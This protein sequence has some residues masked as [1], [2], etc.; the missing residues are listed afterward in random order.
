MTTTNTELVKPSLPKRVPE[1]TLHPFCEIIP[2][3]TAKEFAELKEDIKK[4]GLQVPVKLLTDQI[5]DGRSRYNACI[6]LEKEGV[7]ID[8]K[9][10]A[11]SGTQKDALA[12]VISMNVKRRQLT[13]SQRAIIAAKLVNSSVGGDR[14]S[15]KLPN[16]VT[17]EDVARLSGVAKKMVTDAA[18][19][20]KAKRPDLADKVLKGELA[21][22]KAAKT[23]RQEEKAKKGNP[24]SEDD[25]KADKA[26]KAYHAL[27]EKLIDALSDLGK[28]SSLT[29]ARECAKSTKTR[30]DETIETLRKEEKEAA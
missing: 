7:R 8:F 5:L 17:Q 22:N 21:V 12:Y 15:V 20:L 30:L 25:D 9:T 1:L 28:V 6:E 19:V 27:Q 13:P 24:A 23:I 11:F 18:K 10:D 29:H 4:N 3:C 26:A 2:P 14:H 16:E